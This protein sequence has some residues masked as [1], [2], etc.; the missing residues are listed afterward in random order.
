MCT[1][2]SIIH[3]HSTVWCLKSELWTLLLNNEQTDK[4]THSTLHQSLHA[5]PP[6]WPYLEILTSTVPCQTASQN[7]TCTWMQLNL[8]Y[9]LN[10]VGHLYSWGKKSLAGGRDFFDTDCTSK[11]V[12]VCYHGC[13][14]ITLELALASVPGGGGGG[15]ESS[16]EWSWISYNQSDS[17]KI[18]L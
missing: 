11:N 3:C 16:W 17:F 2:R 10:F 18:S 9:V 13:C 12:H 6:V 4:Q 14:V 1:F 7:D 15:A 8:L 5:S